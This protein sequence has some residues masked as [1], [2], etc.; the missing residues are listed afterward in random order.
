M[1]WTL[2]PQRSL[3]FL[4]GYTKIQRNQS[5]RIRVDFEEKSFTRPEGIAVRESNA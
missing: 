3:A 2:K 5:Y 4:F 1:K